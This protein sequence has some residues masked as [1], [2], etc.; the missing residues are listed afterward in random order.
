MSCQEF[1][2]LH[3]QHAVGGG[4][5][6]TGTAEEGAA[7]EMNRNSTTRSQEE[8]VGLRKAP[9]SAPDLYSPSDPMKEREREPR[10]RRVSLKNNKV[11]SGDA[12]SVAAAKVII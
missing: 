6:R 5:I 8:Q 10:R 1:V 12:G 4:R 11:S 7:R 3:A 9:P 2:G